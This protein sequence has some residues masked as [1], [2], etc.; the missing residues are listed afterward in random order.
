MRGSF[1]LRNLPH[2]EERELYSLVRRVQGSVCDYLPTLPPFPNWPP[3]FTPQTLQFF[4]DVQEMWL[5]IGQKFERIDPRVSFHYSHDDR[6]PIDTQ[7]LPTLNLQALFPEETLI[8]QLRV[9]EK[10]GISVFLM[11][12]SVERSQIKLLLKDGAVRMQFL[13]PHYNCYHELH[14]DLRARGITLEEA[15]QQQH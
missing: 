2:P 8:T 7:I 11:T 9:A 5:K 1:S 14:D 6:T 13:D 12:E 4:P 10:Q 3:A 15:M